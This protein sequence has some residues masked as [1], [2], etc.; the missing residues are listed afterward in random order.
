MSYKVKSIKKI[1]KNKSVLD[2]EI[3]PG[4]LKKSMES[5]YKDISGKAKIPGF[6]KGKVPYNVIDLNFGKEYVLNEAA[7]IAI[8]QLYPEIIEESKIKPIDYP[9]I[10]INKIGEGQPLN[11]AITVEVEPEVTLPKYRGIRVTGITEEVTA[12]EVEK[13][14]ER[15]RNNYATLE[16]VEEK[17]PA[18]KGDFV[19]VDFDGKINGE[20]FE[21]NN[22]R[23]FT[24]EIGSNTLFK[25]FE[26]SL[27]GMKKGDHKEVSLVLPEEISNIALSG[28]EAVFNIDLK[29]IKIKNLP[30]LDKSFIKNFGEYE[31]LEGFK[32]YLHERIREQKRIARKER[33]L[34]DIINH[35]VDNSN[36]EAPG[37]MVNNRINFYNE[38]LEK[39]LKEYK[40][41]RDDY[42]KSY[43]LTEEQF[44]DNLKKAAE[45]EVREYLIFMSLE[46][47]ESKNIEPSEEQIEEEIKKLEAS[48]EKEE[49]KNKLKTFI[50][51]PEGK[52]ELT[53]RIKRRNLL[54]LLIKEAKVIEEKVDKQ[55][56][57][58]VKKKLW[59]PNRKDSGQEESSGDKELW[60]PESSKINEES[61]DRYDENNK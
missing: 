25:D 32:E 1:D 24:L 23:D 33:I 22:A 53:S 13:Q 4:Y 7:T 27:I 12:D 20:D 52:K 34:S 56:G 61:D 3:E 18:Q 59:L 45:R 28:K 26:N 60:V 6:R 11:F 55:D 48:Y 5:A 44:N 19:T 41:T 42:L 17:R 14:V 15:L 40:I 36:F 47:A 58:A 29:D 2:V 57:A 21:G 16:N 54:E 30:A 51:S 8:S 37:A 46:K 31:D 49:D 39:K 9:E 10:K 35:L 38:D 43:N 50:E